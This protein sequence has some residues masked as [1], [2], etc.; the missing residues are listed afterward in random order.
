MRRCNART[1]LACRKEAKE[2]IRLSHGI[3]A[4]SRTT[5]KRLWLL[6]V[7]TNLL[8]KRPRAGHVR[9]PQLSTGWSKTG[10]HYHL[11]NTIVLKPVNS[12]QYLTIER[13]RKVMK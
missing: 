7:Y 6:G 4:Y 2:W 9:G 11:I 13:E 12:R 8:N 10:S 1:L 5:F 3:V